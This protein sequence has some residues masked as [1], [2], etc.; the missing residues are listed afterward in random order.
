MNG[1]QPAQVICSA[2]RHHANFAGALDLQGFS[3]QWPMLLAT[4]QGMVRFEAFRCALHMVTKIYE[5]E[6]F[7]K[8]NYK[9]I[10]SIELGV[11]Y[12][13]SFEN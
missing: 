13:F 3:L 5:V 10:L 9:Y 8:I 4:L 6:S 12:D 1:M 11:C 2:E 7:R